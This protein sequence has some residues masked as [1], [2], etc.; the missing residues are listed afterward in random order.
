MKEGRPTFGIGEQ[1]VVAAR[2][3]EV[4]LN[5]HYTSGMCVQRVFIHSAI[6]SLIHSM[7]VVSDM[8]VFFVVVLGDR[9]EARRLRWHDFNKKGGADN[10]VLCVRRGG[11]QGRRKARRE[12]GEG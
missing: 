2:P 7:S 10:Y 3:R 4:L 5:L 11:S 12:T 8:R 1:G 6:H 9:R